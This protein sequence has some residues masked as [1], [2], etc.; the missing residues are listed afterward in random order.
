M[1]K[2]LFVGISTLLMLLATISSSFACTWWNYQPKTPKSLQ[3]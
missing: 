2:S 3:K 1:K